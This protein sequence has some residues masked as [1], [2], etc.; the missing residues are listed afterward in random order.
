MN[1]DE[2][3]K[4]LE[5]V[6]KKMMESD[7]KEVDEDLDDEYWNK[8]VNK[9]EKSAK[10]LM[11]IP[12]NVPG[13]GKTEMAPIGQYYHDQMIAVAKPPH[14]PIQ[15]VRAKPG[16]KQDINA[17]DKVVCPQCG[18]NSLHT[19][20]IPEDSLQSKPDYQ[21]TNC[22]RLFS[23]QEIMD[24]LGPAKMETLLESNTPE[25][26][27]PARWSPKALKET[28]FVLGLKE[29]VGFDL[30]KNL[31][32]IKDYVSSNEY[33]QLIRG[34][35][36]DYEDTDVRRIIGILQEA[37][38]NWWSPYETAKKIAVITKDTVRAELIARTEL[39]RIA[40]EGN[41]R[42]MKNKGAK[43]MIWISAPEDGRLCDKCKANDNKIFDID[44]GT[45]PPLH[46]RCRCTTAPFYP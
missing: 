36:D 8:Q 17:G 14:L 3:N 19:V 1:D 16:I 15:E 18:K 5:W 43:K 24:V 28:D 34:Y 10:N 11:S 9:A 30:S 27:N 13:T 39:I 32:S 35:L 7:D 33:F 38:N 37:V 46:P 23:N 2:F 20:A 25:N 6:A 40:N 21:C 45:R 26:P 41:I 44:G 12:V 29:Y 4:G 31:A 42:D 22:G